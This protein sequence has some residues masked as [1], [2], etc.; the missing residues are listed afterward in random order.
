MNFVEKVM[1]QLVGSS[2]AK[3]E[4]RRNGYELI[5]V[6]MRLISRYNAMNWA[7]DEYQS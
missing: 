6:D 5:F 4:S 3:D 1:L 7:E 2:W